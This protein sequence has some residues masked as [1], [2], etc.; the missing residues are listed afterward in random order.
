MQNIVGT[1]RVINLTG[2]PLQMII[3]WDGL[4]AEG[5]LPYLWVRSP[6][7]GQC[8]IKPSGIAQ[9][10]SLMDFGMDDYINEL[11]VKLGVLFEC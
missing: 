1:E 2:E 8:S 11:S 10:E 9:K 3:P 5:I 4:P 7:V 6:P